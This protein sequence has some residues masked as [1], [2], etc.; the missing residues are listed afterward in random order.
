MTSPEQAYLDLIKAGGKT[1]EDA[2]TKLFDQLKPI[3]PSFLMGEWKGGDFD[4]GHP[5]TQALK[6]INWAGKT[7]RA[8]DDVDPTVVHGEGGKRV[9]LEEYGGARVREMKFRGV[10]SAA[11]VHD[12]RAI[13]DHFRFVDEDT[14]AGMIDLKTSSLVGFLGMMDGKTLPPGYHFHLIRCRPTDTKL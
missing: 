8:E 2:A 11:M 9:P 12:D 7:F 10:V 13:I 3:E 5:L 14:V 6:R 4:T 1:S